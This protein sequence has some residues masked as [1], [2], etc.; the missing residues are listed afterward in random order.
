MIDFNISLDSDFSKI[1]S[2]DEN[3]QLNSSFLLKK[4]Y[5]RVRITSLDSK[6]LEDYLSLS[7]GNNF[8]S[9]FLSN[10]E[11]ESEDWDLTD[12]TTEY[13]IVKIREYIIN[14]K[15]DFIVGDYAFTQF[16]SKSGY[17][18]RM[19]KDL[20]GGVIH[21]LGEI[22]NCQVFLNRVSTNT[23]SIFGNR[24]C[25]KY[26]FCLESTQIE[27]DE[28]DLNIDLNYSLDFDLDLSGIRKFFVW[29]DR[30]SLPKDLVRLKSIDKILK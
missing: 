27:Q 15:I 29:I 12:F 19:P 8:C 13:Q 5:S 3:I 23:S 20:K 10:L 22:F 26:N 25:L 18:N 1:F 6:N 16:L 9:L 7:L 2:K 17:F 24:E 14:N 30:A 11:L 21:Y 4:K 28:E